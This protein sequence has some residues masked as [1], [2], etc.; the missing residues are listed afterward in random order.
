MGSR[1]QL[2]RGTAAF[3]MDENPVLHQGEPG[4]ETNTRKLKIGDGETFWRD[5]PYYTGLNIGE[6]TDDAT[7][8]QL[9]LNHISSATPHSVYDDG[10]SLVLIY[11]NAKV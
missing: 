4:Y 7:A 11:E 1:I 10:P 2:R 3:W 6:G 8:M 9:I 5:L